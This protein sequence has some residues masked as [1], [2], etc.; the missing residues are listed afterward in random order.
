MQEASSW[1]SMI[2]LVDAGIGVSIAPASARA[3]RPRGVTFCDLDGA[4]GRAELAL[5]Y[6]HHPLSPAAERF[7]QIAKQE[8]TDLDSQG[9]ASVLG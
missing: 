6:P 1:S 7:R 4:N 5:A 9:F 2:S 3:L 8:A